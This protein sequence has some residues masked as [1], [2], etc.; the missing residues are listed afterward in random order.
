MNISD[1][2][3]SIASGKIEK[4][5]APKKKKET[6]EAKDSVQLG[7]SMAAPE[8]PKMAEGKKVEVEPEEKKS[9]SSGKSKEGVNL[10]FIHMNDFHGYVEELDK[11]EGQEH[12]IGV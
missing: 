8:T 11:P 10:K 5:A 7:T 9:A 12:I 6:E 4:K 1:I 2:G 3:K